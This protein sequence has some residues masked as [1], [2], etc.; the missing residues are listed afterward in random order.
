M[1]KVSDVHTKLYHYTTWT[2]LAGIL[3]TQSLWATHYKFLNDYSEI[4][5]FKEKLIAMTAPYVHKTYEEWL[6]QEPQLVEQVNMDGGIGQ[7]VHHDTAVFVEAQYNATGDEIYVV[8]FCGQS[9]DPHVNN[10]GLLSQW[11]GY[12]IGGG[13]V[14]VL[15]AAKLEELL[16]QEVRNRNYRMIHLS[17]VV[18]SGN[19]EKMLEEFAPDL[20]VL[21]EDV[22]ALA[23]VSGGS[24]Q[25][26]I[27]RGF[28]SFVNCITRYK[29][30]GF[31]EE[32]E[33]RIVALP[34]TLDE[35]QLRE[36]DKTGTSIPPAKERKFRTQQGER[37]P[38]IELFGSV[39]ANLPIEAIIVGPHKDKEQRASAL[40]AMLRGTESEV[41]CSDI[42]FVG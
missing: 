37:I 17:D 23:S 22:K 14:L 29:H 34:E 25:D 7:L 5:F 42:P 9:P 11:R 15:N 20:G 38:Y 19:E 30:Y 18:Y 35:D 32:N 28:R 13:F 40:R 3:Q 39:S 8:S 24:N 4:I 33:V 16:E 1:L 36:I 2:G 27:F 6:K 26:E 12:G 10:N 41:I 21:A 31:R